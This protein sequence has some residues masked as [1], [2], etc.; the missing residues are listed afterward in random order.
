MHTE[1]QILPVHDGGEHF[2]KQEFVHLFLLA[3]YESSTHH[4]ERVPL[5]AVRV[6]VPPPEMLYYSIAPYADSVQWGGMIRGTRWNS[7]FHGI[8]DCRV[9]HTEDGRVV[10]IRFGP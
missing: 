2:S 9:F 5:L 7:L 6:G 3:R 10:E 4:P 1:N 8:G